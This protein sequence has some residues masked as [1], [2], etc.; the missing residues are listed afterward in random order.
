MKVL[1]VLSV[2]YC[3][4]DV[5]ASDWSLVQRSPTDCGVCLSVTVKL[6][7]W[8]SP[9]PQLLRHKRKGTKQKHMRDHKCE[10]LPVLDIQVFWDFTLCRL[11]NSYLRPG[12]S[13]GLQIPGLYRRLCRPHRLWRWRQHADPTRRHL[14]TIWHRANPWITESPSHTFENFRVTYL[15]AP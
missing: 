9:D 1:S 8:P 4:V 2:V 14:F 5:S 3:P 10:R 7:Q 15:S 11:A 13:Y 6:R 12:V